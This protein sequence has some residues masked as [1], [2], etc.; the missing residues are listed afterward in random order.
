M[1]RSGDSGRQKDGLSW[2]APLEP[3]WWSDWIG[4]RFDGHQRLLLPFWLNVAIWM[5]DHT[6]RLA[7]HLLESG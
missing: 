2:D 6:Q 3:L 5:R 4:L 7:N 1:I